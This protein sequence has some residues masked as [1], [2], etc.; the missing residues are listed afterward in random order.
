VNPTRVGWRSPEA[1]WGEFA[2]D[3]PL[4]EAGFEPS[5]PLIETI[6]PPSDPNSKAGPRGRAESQIHLAIP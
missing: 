4:E 6:E 3:S 2:R 1:V 5:V